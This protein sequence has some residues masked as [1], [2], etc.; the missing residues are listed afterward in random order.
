MDQE[1]KDEELYKAALAAFF[2]NEMEADKILTG[3]SIDSI[4]L[5]MDFFIYK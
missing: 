3:L 1:Q 5:Y 4:G 2:K